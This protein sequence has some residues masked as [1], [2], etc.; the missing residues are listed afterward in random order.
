VVEFNKGERVL[1]RCGNGTLTDAR[2]ISVNY[3]LNPNL[4]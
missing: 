2:V 4:N 1:Y 3:K